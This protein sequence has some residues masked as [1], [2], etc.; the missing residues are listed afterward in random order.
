MVTVHEPEETMPPPPHHSLSTTPPPPPHAMPTKPTPSVTKHAET[1][2]PTASGTEEGD[3]SSMYA[4]ATLTHA[5]TETPLRVKSSNVT[6]KRRKTSMRLH[7]STDAETSPLL[8]TQ[9]MAW[10]RRMREQP[11]NALHGYS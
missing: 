1:Y 2:S 7:A 5:H 11:S 9:L 3:V 6:P 4:S 10:P 8:Y